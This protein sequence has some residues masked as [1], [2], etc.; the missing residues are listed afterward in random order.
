MVTKNSA[1]PDIA[2]PPGEYLAEEIRARGIS[3]KELA[4]RMGRPLNPINEIING[5]KAITAETA[6]QLEEVMP[7]IPARFWLNLE[8]DYQLTRALINKRAKVA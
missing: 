3:Q 5:K 1:Y 8:A 7:E 6:L 2:I 4:R